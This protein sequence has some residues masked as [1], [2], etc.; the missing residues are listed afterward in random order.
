[1]SSYLTINLL[2]TNYFTAREF[3][4]YEKLFVLLGEKVWIHF[5]WD[6]LYFNF[7]GGGAHNG[8]PSIPRT[9]LSRKKG[10]ETN[11][12]FYLG[13]KLII[14]YMR[15]QKNVIVIAVPFLTMLNLNFVVF[16]FC[17]VLYNRSYPIKKVFSCRILSNE[18]RSL[19][20]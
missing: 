11:H 5:F 8:G 1:M 14:S 4:I 12:L 7:T 2:P 20:S 6:T 19:I 15:R 13:L 18:I 16:L 10:Q 3:Q 17:T 9:S